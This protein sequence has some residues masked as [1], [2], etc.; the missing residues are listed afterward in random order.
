MSA[1]AIVAWYFMIVA[2]FWGRIARAVGK[3]DLPE[4]GQFQKSQLL[5]KMEASYVTQ[6]EKG[7]WPFRKMKPVY[8]YFTYGLRGAV[9]GFAVSV[10]L[11]FLF[12]LCMA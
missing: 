7:K 10:V 3:V 2:L 6:L 8:S 12:N 11:V 1:T 4:N 9:F 5:K